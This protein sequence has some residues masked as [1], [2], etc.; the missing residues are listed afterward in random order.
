M[1]ALNIATDIPSNINTTEKLA[2]WLAD[3]HNA[4]YG[5]VNGI[6]GENYTQRVATASTFP[7][8][9][10]NTTVHVSR[11]AIKLPNDFAVLGGKRWQYAQDLGTKTL[12][13]AMKAN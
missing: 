6:E 3:V 4:L 2:V 7:I 8:A 9:A 12:T 10:N 13:A 11:S 1:T 5:D